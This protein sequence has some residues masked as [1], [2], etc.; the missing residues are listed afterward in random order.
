MPYCGFCGR[1]CP[2]VPGLNR[3]IDN[4]PKCKK[5]SFEEFGQ[6]ANSLWDDI[7]ENLNDAEQ[8][9]LQHL[10]NEPDDFYL[11]EDFEIAEQI[12]NREENDLLPHPP[13]LLDEP[14]LNPQH[15]T[16]GDVPEKDD[17]DC[18]R[19]IENFPE[20]YQAGATWGNCK[21]LY[22]FLDEKQKEGGSRYG[23]FDDEEE[24]QLAE[25][26]I[27]NVGQKQTDMFL[28]L[29]IVGFFSFT[30]F[31]S[32]LMMDRPKNEHNPPIVIT[33]TS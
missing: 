6:Y 18:S 22:E 19:Y 7:P 2:T 24:W 3:H 8:Q 16:V 4:T 32:I 9:P 29:P 21:P 23:P 15:S 13:P 26:L 28:K 27:R 12:F 14:Q 11:D 17:T 33:R 31:V 1:L 30:I 25:W 20:E 10:P 5:A